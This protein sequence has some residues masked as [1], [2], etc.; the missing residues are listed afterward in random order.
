MDHRDKMYDLLFSTAALT[1][2]EDPN[3]KVHHVL[4]AAA[5]FLVNNIKICQRYNPNIHVAAL[6]HVIELLDDVTCRLADEEELN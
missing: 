6:Q 4:G 2:E 5:L 3:I 1:M